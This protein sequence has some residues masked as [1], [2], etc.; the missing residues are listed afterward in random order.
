MTELLKELSEVL[1]AWKAV[2]P[3]VGQLQGVKD[4]RLLDE[5]WTSAMRAAI[6]V[7]AKLQA[8]GRGDLEEKLAV[9]KGVMSE[10]Y[11]GYRETPLLVE[12][13][14]IRK[15]D[16]EFCEAS[17]GKQKGSAGDVSSNLQVCGR[18]GEVHALWRYV[19]HLEMTSC[20]E[21]PQADEPLAPVLR[22]RNCRICQEPMGSRDLKD[23]E[24]RLLLCD[25]S[26]GLRD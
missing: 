10:L 2:N 13:C 25:R 8:L 4:L 20:G 11:A 6:L 14:V 7:M 17:I 1:D 15:A 19:N 23:G 18:H 3:D 16:G 26:S 9:A 24:L 21:H 22:N 5:E 12:T